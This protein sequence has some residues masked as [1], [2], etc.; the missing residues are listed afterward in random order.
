MVCLWL[1]QR[2]AHLVL[3]PVREPKAVKPTA[4]RWQ[5]PFKVARVSQQYHTWAEASQKTEHP[6]WEF[7][8]PHKDLIGLIL[9]VVPATLKEN[10]VTDVAEAEGDPKKVYV[11]AKALPVSGY[12][13]GSKDVPQQEWADIYRAL[14]SKYQEALKA[15]RALGATEG[16]INAAIGYWFGLSGLE[17]EFLDTTKGRV[18]VGL[19]TAGT[20]D[21]GALIG[22]WVAVHALDRLSPLTLAT[23][24]NLYRRYLAEGEDPDAQQ[25]L[26]VLGKVRDAAKRIIQDVLF[27]VLDEAWTSPSWEVVR[28]TMEAKGYDPKQFFKDLEI[29]ATYLLEHDKTL[30]STF[31]IEVQPKGKTDEP[32]ELGDGKRIKIGQFIINWDTLKKRI[33]SGSGL[34]GDRAFLLDWVLQHTTRKEN[35][36]L[37]TGQEKPFWEI[38][39]Q[40]MPDEQFKDLRKAFREPL[41]QPIPEPLKSIASEI[42]HNLAQVSERDVKGVDDIKD[43]LEH[44]LDAEDWWELL[45]GDKPA[46][47]DAFV[48]YL[49]RVAEMAYFN[50]PQPTPQEPILS[51]PTSHVTEMRSWL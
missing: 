11:S 42:L 7:E 30:L 44:F 48:A 23:L 2:Y 40:K 10:L 8:T 47:E 21:G 32:V 50:K 12:L 45:E 20:S 37:M 18:L 6:Y 34:R 29:V 31:G 19:G 39:G 36:I 13:I 51:V 43:R 14:W 24:K 1:K 5:N 17:D 41:E 28:A 22:H 15:E 4:L 27:G 9:N 35:E 25:K 38:V 46:L 49:Y 33:Y 16:E 3:L 26:E